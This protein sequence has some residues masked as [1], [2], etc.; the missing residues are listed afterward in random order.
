MNMVR[1]RYESNKT[2]VQLV[3]SVYPILSTRSTAATFL[4]SK[5]TC[6]IFLRPSFLQGSDE[7]NF[8]GVF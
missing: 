7:Q 5:I 8:Q 6:E 1:Q 4:H 2:K 3:E